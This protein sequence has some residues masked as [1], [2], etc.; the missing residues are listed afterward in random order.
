MK[1]TIDNINRGIMLIRYDNYLALWT[2]SSLFTT[3][4]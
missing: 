2:P 3:Y 4:L 1:N